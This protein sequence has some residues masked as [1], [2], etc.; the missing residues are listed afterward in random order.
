MKGNRHE[1]TEKWFW[2]LVFTKHERLRPLAAEVRLVSSAR[3]RQLARVHC[4]TWFCDLVLLGSCKRVIG[5][6][7]TE[8]FIAFLDGAERYL[9]PRKLRSAAGIE[10]YI[11]EERPDFVRFLRE[12]GSL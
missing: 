7:C 1:A 10:Q 3:A 12:P 6:H 2:E 4:R 11:H 8:R 5:Y 9:V